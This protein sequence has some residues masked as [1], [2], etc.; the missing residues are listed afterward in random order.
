MS[1]LD[2]IEDYLQEAGCFVNGLNDRPAHMDSYMTVLEYPK[3]N[4]ALDSPPFTKEE[5]L[6]AADNMIYFGYLSPIAA[7]TG[8]IIKRKYEGK[9]NA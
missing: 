4:K 3:L 8:K 9:V 7:L 1:K 6:E 2:E 5:L